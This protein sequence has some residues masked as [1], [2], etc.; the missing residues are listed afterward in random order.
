M[1]L[2]I[3]IIHAIIVRFMEIM[4]VHVLKTSIEELTVEDIRTLRMAR[5]NT[6]ESN[7]RYGEKSFMEILLEGSRKLNQEFANSDEYKME[8]GDSE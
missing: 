5:G 3:I 2:I 7:H 4:E 8:L 6:R 1:A